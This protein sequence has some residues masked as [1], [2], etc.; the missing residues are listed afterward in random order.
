MILSL[1]RRNLK[2]I[3]KELT[4]NKHTLYFY[5]IIPGSLRSRSG[6]FYFTK[7]WGYC[8][9]IRGDLFFPPPS[10]KILIKKNDQDF[11]CQAHTNFRIKKNDPKISWRLE[12]TFTQ[13]IFLVRALIIEIRI[14]R[15]KAAY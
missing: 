1:M 6:F 3:L 12:H 5:L 10:L 11:F 2:F 8:G 7:L 14:L 4:K 9:D 15:N 13:I